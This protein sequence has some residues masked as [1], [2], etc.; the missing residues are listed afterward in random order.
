M[1][2]G[3]LRD[4]ESLSQ[5]YTVGKWYGWDPSPDLGDGNTWSHRRHIYENHMSRAENEGSIMS[6]HREFV[7]LM[8]KDT[9]FSQHARKNASIFF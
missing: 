7:E 9:N 1:R 5:D 3:K 4:V 2:K 6:L 8:V